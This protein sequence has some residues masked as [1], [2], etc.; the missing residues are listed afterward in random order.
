MTFS[1]CHDVAKAGKRCPG[2]AHTC[3]RVFEKGN[4]PDS[5]HWQQSEQLWPEYGSINYSIF[6]KWNTTTDI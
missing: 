2:E 6:P 4:I 1:V 5:E 3:Q